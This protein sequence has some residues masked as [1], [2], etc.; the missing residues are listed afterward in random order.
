MVGVNLGATAIVVATVTGMNRVGRGFLHRRF[1][2][3]VRQLAVDKEIERSEAEAELIAGAKIVAIARV[4]VYLAVGVKC[5]RLDSWGG[6]WSFWVTRVV[7]P[8]FATVI[9]CENVV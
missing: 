7:R 5:N 6:G 1:A 4:G 3:M 9:L 2:A 8:A